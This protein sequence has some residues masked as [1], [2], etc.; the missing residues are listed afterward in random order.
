MEPRLNP[1]SPRPVGHTSQSDVDTHPR[2]DLV[3]KRARPAQRRRPGGR[4]RARLLADLN[5]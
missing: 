4:A 1:M 2:K 3:S 5:A